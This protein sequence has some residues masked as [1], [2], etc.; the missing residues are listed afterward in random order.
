ME[1]R[2]FQ[3]P[4][5]EFIKDISLQFLITCT[6]NKL[7]LISIQ[8]CFVWIHDLFITLSIIKNKISIGFSIQ[9]S[10]SDIHLFDIKRLFTFEYNFHK[11]WKPVES[12]HFNWGISP[13]WDIFIVMKCKTISQEHVERTTLQKWLKIMC[14]T[15]PIFLNSCRAMH[16]LLLPINDGFRRRITLKYGMIYDY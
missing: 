13:L 3:I 5:P 6:A 4:F 1:S 14:N 9:K 11:W 16:L 2:E 15:K 8:T 12:Y 10:Y 7:F